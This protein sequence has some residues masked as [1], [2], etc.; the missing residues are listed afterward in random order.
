MINGKETMNL[1]GN[2]RRNTEGV[3]ARNCIIIF[4][5]IKINKLFKPEHAKAQAHNYPRTLE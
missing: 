5:K 1:R 2:K 3:E 4:L